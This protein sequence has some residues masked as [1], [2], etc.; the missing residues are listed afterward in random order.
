MSSHT[1]PPEPPSSPPST[2]A[3][4]PAVSVPASTR[5]SRQHHPSSHP[6]PF[7]RI[8]RATRWMAGVPRAAW[9]C[10]L[11]ACLSAASWSLITPP[12]ESPDEPSHF[13]YVQQL[14]ETGHIPTGKEGS[15]SFEEETALTELRMPQV[16]WH[17]EALTLSSA[18]GQRRLDQA[19]KGP[20]G[21]TDGGYAAVAASEPPLYYAL[22]TI[23]Y[24]LGSSGTILT[25]LTLMRLL[26]VLMAGLT[27]LFCY[28]FLREVFSDS[29]SL[30]LVGG[31]CVALAP[32][33]GF[34][35]GVVNPDSMLYAVSAATFYMLARG[36]RRGLTPRLAVALGVVTAAGML[37]KVNFLG[38]LPGLGVGAVVLVVRAA[39]RNKLSRR[40]CAALVLAVSIPAA[41]VCGYVAINLLLGH[42]GL[43]LVSSAFHYTSA[44]ASPLSELSYM[45][46]FYLPRLP[47]MVNYFPGL[48]MTRDAWFARS[49]GLYGWLDSPFPLWV[50]D[51]AMIPVGIVL[52]L[53]AHGL[54]RSRSMLRGRRAE[55]AVY[56]IMAL[57]LM[58]LIAGDS[59]IHR[60][61]EGGGWV[62][63]RYLLPLLPLLAVLP[64][65][66]ARGAGRRWGPAV[67]TLI[68]LLVFSHDIFSQLQ[69]VV[70][71]Y[72]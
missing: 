15:F 14:A 54:F 20:L 42:A 6:R 5:R 2:D 65:L 64:A 56:A 28:L 41:P 11:I 23:P 12:F 48:S 1:A 35:S 24:Y 61:I 10:A 62:Q 70:R 30:P 44:D 33:L 71:Y 31:L 19:L 36:F 18:R 72:G 37:T 60:H 16:L 59:Y 9:A 68:V 34:M 26:S 69:M 38:L 50:D 45:W 32:L 58:V 13:A 67:G 22:E 47:G 46:Q 51:L 4:D 63:P 17:P 39:R 66:A 55:L 53:G 40:F 21:R 57:G 43:G 49:V 7:E 52:A 25:R 27:A 3:R 8:A 29:R